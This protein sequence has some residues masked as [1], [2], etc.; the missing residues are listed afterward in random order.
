VWFLGQRAVDVLVANNDIAHTL[1]AR[2]FA[3][4]GGLH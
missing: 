3:I 2:K 1:V 4:M